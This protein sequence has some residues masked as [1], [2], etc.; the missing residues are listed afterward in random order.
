MVKS[1]L[2]KEED[3][4]KKHYQRMSIEDLAKKFDVSPAAIRKKEKKL[5]LLREHSPRKGEKKKKKV[6][7]PVSRK[8]TEKEEDYLRKHYL[9]KTNVELAKRFR[10]TAKSV[11]KKLWRMG[12]KKRGKSAKDR[13]EERRRKIE[14]FL[15]RKRQ[16]IKEKKVDEHR[17]QAI[18]EFDVAIRFYYD[19]KYKKAEVAFK[20]VIKDY[21]D[22][23]DIVYKAKQYAKFCLDKK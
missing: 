15:G 2:K 19:K 14:E 4:L 23:S 6:T 1:W 22:V 10:T 13:E 12:L 7:P 20:K 5:G 11:E 3:F 8:W 18:A 17:S 21:A 9:K 16:V